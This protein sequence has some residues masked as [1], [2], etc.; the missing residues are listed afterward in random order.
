MK[1]TLALALLLAGSAVS[2]PANVLLLDF[3]PTATA[4]TQAAN[5]PYA[6]GLGPTSSW[7]TVGTADV[8]SGLLFFDGSSAAGVSLDLGASGSSFTGGTSSV[9]FSTQPTGTN[10]GTNSGSLLVTDSPAKDFVFTGTSGQNTAVG[11][12]IGGLDAGTYDIYLVGYNSAAATTN[13]GMQFWASGTAGAPTLGVADVGSWSTASVTNGSFT[14]WTEGTNYAVI[15]V[16]LT[17]GQ[18]LTVLSHG[19]NAS[20]LRGF[21]NLVQVVQTSTIPEPSAAALLLGCAVLGAV[22]RR[23]RRSL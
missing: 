19:T 5:A 18:N 3:G 7:N 13:R 22:V 4:S 16:S 15:S 8:G 2:L 21:L 11:L 10:A 17:A 14:A 23:R 1:K 9:N 20:E 12:S 6:T